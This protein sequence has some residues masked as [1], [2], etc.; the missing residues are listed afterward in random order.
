MRGRARLALGLF[1]VDNRKVGWDK[2]KIW[3]AAKKSQPVLE[4]RRYTDGIFA[5]GIVFRENPEQSLSVVRITPE[6][7]PLVFM[8]DHTESF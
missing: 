8:I 2:R 7:L 3:S 4:T 1:S 6:Q 5:A